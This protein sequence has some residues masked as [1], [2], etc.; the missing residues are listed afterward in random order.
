MPSI[1]YGWIYAQWD[2]RKEIIRV[3]IY[4]I[5]LSICNITRERKEHTQKKRSQHNAS[6]LR[7]LGKI[8]RQAKQ[9]AVEESPVLKLKRGCCGMLV[10]VT[11]STFFFLL[12]L[13]LLSGRSNAVPCQFSLFDSSN[14][15]ARTHKTYA[16]QFLCAYRCV[17]RHFF[18]TQS[19]DLHKITC[20]VI[21]TKISHVSFSQQ[22]QNKYYTSRTYTRLKDGPE[23]IFQ[24]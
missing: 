21:Q 17:P 24:I 7:E 8:T 14:L 6:T 4:T 20:N 13:L 3:I 15:H 9:C 10:F 19:N 18:F 5:P 11:E 23:H 22:N 2:Q 12:I 16:K 1:Y